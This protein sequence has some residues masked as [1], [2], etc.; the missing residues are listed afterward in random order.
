MKPVN[1]PVD[2]MGR[3]SIPSDPSGFS[4]KTTVSRVASFFLS[5][6]VCL[7]GQMPEVFAQALKNEM[8]TP[9]LRRF[10]ST[11]EAQ[12]ARYKG[13]FLLSVPDATGMAALTFDDGPDAVWTPRILDILK[14]KKATASF[15]FLG[16]LVAGKPDAVAR[17]AAEGHDVLSHSMSHA[18]WRKSTPDEVLHSEVLPSFDAIDKALGRKVPRLVRPPY[19]AVTD[20]QIERLSAAGCIVIDWSIDTFDWDRKIGDPEAIVERVLSLAGPGDVILMHS[21]GGRRAA[22]AEALPG[23]IDGLRKLG[24]EPVSLTRLLAEEKRRPRPEEQK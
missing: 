9:Q 7:A 3:T 23:I 11:V 12:A 4:R 5:A 15:F 16:K 6:L 1:A 14:E 8:H 10:K 22:T 2:S 24:M 13:K 21:G 20:D 18:D 17:A 19:G